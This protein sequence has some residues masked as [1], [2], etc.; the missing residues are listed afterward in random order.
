MSEKKLEA[1]RE[2]IMRELEKLGLYQYQ[3]DCFNAQNNVSGL[4][5][6]TAQIDKLEARIRA[7]IARMDAAEV[8]LRVKAEHKAFKASCVVRIG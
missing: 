7:K 1:L 6:K 2:T 4:N 8:V 3:A 5:R